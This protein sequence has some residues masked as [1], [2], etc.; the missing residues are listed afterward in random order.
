MHDMKKGKKMLA[1]LI[2]ILCNLK[3]AIFNISLYCN[4]HNF[5]QIIQKKI[6]A[7]WIFFQT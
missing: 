1:F 4:E 6:L 3:A 2:Y 5:L 7:E